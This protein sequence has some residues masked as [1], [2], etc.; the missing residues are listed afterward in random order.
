MKRAIR[1]TD[2]R[3]WLTECCFNAK[4]TL[5]LSSEDIAYCLIQTAYSMLSKIICLNMEK[6]SSKKMEF[7]SW[8]FQTCDD[9]E[10]KLDCSCAEIADSLLFLARNYLSDTIIIMGEIE[11]MAEYAAKKSPIG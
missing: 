4:S 11:D 6:Q 2:L 9:A 8:L 3:I 10:K 1:T 7:V 5:N